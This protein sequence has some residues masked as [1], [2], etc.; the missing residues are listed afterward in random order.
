MRCHKCHW[1]MN[2]TSSEMWLIHKL[3]SASA[4]D[5]FKRIRTVFAAVFEE[6]G[7]FALQWR[8]RGL[9]GLKIR[10]RSINLVASTATSGN[11][12]DSGS[13]SS[14]SSSSNS[15]SSSKSSSSSIGIL[16][17]CRPSRVLPVI[18]LTNLKPSFTLHAPRRP[19]SQIPSTGSQ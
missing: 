14:S 7:Y 9:K 17:E 4:G 15:D 2:V 1:A 8:P 10:V 3:H 6:L 19:D 11:S 13:S 16:R 5:A 18:T 12:G